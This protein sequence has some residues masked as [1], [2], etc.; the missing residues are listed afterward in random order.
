MTFPRGTKPNE[1]MMQ[2]TFIT[3]CFARDGCYLRLSEYCEADQSK[4]SK[5]S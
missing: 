2:I 5:I 1:F 3:E 4:I